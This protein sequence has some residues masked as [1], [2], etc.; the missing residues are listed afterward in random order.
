ME[1]RKFEAYKYKGPDLDDLTREIFLNEIKDAIVD[2]KTLFGYNNNGS[3][4]DI[5]NE[6]LYIYIDK[7]VNNKYINPCVLK[8]DLSDVSL[9]IGQIPFDEETEEEGEFIPELNFDTEVTKKT[10]EF[11]APLKQEFRK[12]NKTINKYNV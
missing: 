9:E 4:Y 2:T 12:F 1:I 8:I 3:M 10:R 7:K 5:E 11:S 6:I